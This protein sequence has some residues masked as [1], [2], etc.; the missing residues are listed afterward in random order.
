MKALIWQLYVLVSL[1]WFSFTRSNQLLLYEN[2][3]YYS[4]SWI[5][6]VQYI[7]QI[8]RNKIASE[9]QYLTN[10]LNFTYIVTF[11]L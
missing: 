5:I 8:Q 4:S 2:E 9:F 6:I 10:I 3:C 11:P 1:F 7:S